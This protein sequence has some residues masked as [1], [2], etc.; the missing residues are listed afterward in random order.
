[1][2]KFQAPQG[3]E[4]A[5]LAPYSPGSEESISELEELILAHVPQLVAIQ[6][7]VGVAA[8]RSEE[9][10]P[11]VVVFADRPLDPLSLPPEI[12]GYPVELEVVPGGFEAQ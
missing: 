8:R 7:V 11:R 10:R 5:A 12:G 4:D 6:G 2:D 3:T 9:G 1:M